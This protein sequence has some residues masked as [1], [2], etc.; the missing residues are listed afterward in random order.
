MNIIFLDVD[1]VLN[2]LAY[3]ESLGR[4]RHICGYNDIS[5][6]HL[7]KLAE[8]YHTCDAKIVL[9]STWRDL[10]DAEETSVNGMYKYLVDS[11]GK[12]DMKIISK[13][14]IIGQNRPLEIATWINNRVDKEDIRFVSLDDDFQKESYDEYGIGQCLVKTVFWSHDF[15]KGGLQ[16]EHVDLAIRI[17]NGNCS[18]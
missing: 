13:T 15:E 11:L 18:C 16:Q 1:G 8:I 10:D 9:S 17:L 3:F 4:S 12:Y 6:Y 5:D 2:S 7:Q 14:P